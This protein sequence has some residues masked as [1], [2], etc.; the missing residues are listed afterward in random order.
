LG[1]GDDDKVRV[2]LR[3]CGFTALISNR[4][5]EVKEIVREAG[6]LAW[7]QMVERG[8][9]WRNRVCCLLTR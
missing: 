5:E 6:K 2:M 3:G 4:S 9:R 8:H 1:K 7:H